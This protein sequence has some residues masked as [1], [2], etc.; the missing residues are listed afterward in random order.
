MQ[1]TAPSASPGI[2]HRAWYPFAFVDRN[3]RPFRVSFRIAEEATWDHHFHDLEGGEIAL[4]ELELLQVDHR[5]IQSSCDHAVGNS[6]LRL[7]PPANGNGG[8]PFAL[9][10]TAASP[11]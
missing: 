7:S 3:A 4:E 8:A 11:A 2:N 5:F 6:N 9:V 1:K 10:G